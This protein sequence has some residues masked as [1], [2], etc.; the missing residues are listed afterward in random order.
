MPLLHRR[1]QCMNLQ[2]SLANPSCVATTWFTEGSAYA[3]PALSK[4][5]GTACISAPNPLTCIL[6]TPCGIS[7]PQWQGQ[8]PHHQGWRCAMWCFICI[9][10]RRSSLQLP[11]CTLF[12]SSS[13]LSSCRSRWHCNAKKAHRIQDSSSYPGISCCIMNQL[14]PAMHKCRWGQERKVRMR[15]WHVI[16]IIHPSEADAGILPLVWG[17]FWLTHLTH[18]FPSPPWKHCLFQHSKH[19]THQRPSVANRVWKQQQTKWSCAV[20]PIERSRSTCNICHRPRSTEKGDRVSW[21]CRLVDAWHGRTTLKIT[22]WQSFVAVWTQRDRSW[23]VVEIE[24]RGKT[25]AH[26]NT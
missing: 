22:T 1:L 13:S 21:V 25:E 11:S 12:F 26:S 19:W 4:D 24:E 3:A 18:A 14:R 16:H 23:P 15:S 20:G 10:R 2:P 9:L 7:F 6:C 8:N 17:I 5:H